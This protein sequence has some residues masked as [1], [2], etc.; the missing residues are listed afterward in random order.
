MP[1]SSLPRVR[2]F[3]VYRETRSVLHQL[4]KNINLRQDQLWDQ[5]NL[6]DQ[7]FVSHITADITATYGW[8]QEQLPWVRWNSWPLVLSLKLLLQQ[9]LHQ[10]LRKP[11]HKRETHLTTSGKRP[12]CYSPPPPSVVT[13]VTVVTILPLAPIKSAGSL[14]HVALANE[15]SRGD[16]EGC[17]HWDPYRSGHSKGTLVFGIGNYCTYCLYVFPYYN[18]ICHTHFFHVCTFFMDCN[19]C[20]ICPI[21]VLILLFVLCQTIPFWP[22]WPLRGLLEQKCLEYLAS[23]NSK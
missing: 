2:R 13:V 1:P 5:K 6:Y 15:V 9:L 22:D 20:W 3:K 19:F 8:T 12:F 4:I 18:I 11:N 21:N 17:S 10:M 16:K 23:R 14:M 7:A